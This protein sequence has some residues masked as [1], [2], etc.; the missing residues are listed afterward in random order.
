MF[1]LK[2]WL[3]LNVQL[4]CSPKS[5]GHMSRDSKIHNLTIHIWILWSNKCFVGIFVVSVIFYLD[6]SKLKYGDER[7]DQWIKYGFASKRSVSHVLWADK[8]SL[9]NPG[10]LLLNTCWNKLP[11]KGNTQRYHSQDLRAMFALDIENITSPLLVIS[12]QAYQYVLII[13]V[14]LFSLSIFSRSSEQ[15]RKDRNWAWY[16]TGESFPFKIA[17]VRKL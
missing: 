9:L 1:L 13:Y 17:F 7:P 15:E 11:P 8:L 16:G 4:E 14:L 5:L 2:D 12:S 10:Y 3:N 6:M